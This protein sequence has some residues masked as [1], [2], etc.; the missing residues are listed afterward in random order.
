MPEIEFPRR[1]CTDFKS[2]IS[3]FRFVSA[4]TAKCRV[5]RSFVS[6]NRQIRAAAY[7]SVSA[8]LSSKL[9]SVQFQSS[10]AKRL[11]RE[12]LVRSY[13]P[14]R[15][16]S[17]VEMM[18]ATR[19]THLGQSRR[20]T[21]SNAGSEFPPDRLMKC[22][23]PGYSTVGRKYPAKRRAGSPLLSTHPLRYRFLKYLAIG[24]R[25]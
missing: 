14:G 3:I 11:T 19:V 24:R 4:H 15:A 10:S 13:I 22:A 25:V 7:R 21:T 8:R 1:H 17:G 5:C 12:V 23:T 18:E 16:Q 20:Q 6:Q 2:A 9:S